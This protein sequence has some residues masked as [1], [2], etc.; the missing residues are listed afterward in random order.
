MDFPNISSWVY[1]RGAYIWGK[2]IVKEDMGLFSG[3]LYTRGLTF[4]VYGIFRHQT[5]P[6]ICPIK[7]CDTQ[8]Y[9]QYRKKLNQTC[10]L[11]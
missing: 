3:T 5:H 9:T 10:L 8:N 11:N 2:K 4:G 6:P 7:G 1:F